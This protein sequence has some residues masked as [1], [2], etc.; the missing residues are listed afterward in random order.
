MTFK[1][2]M[3][4]LWKNKRILQYRCVALN[5]TSGIYLFSRVNEDNENCFYVGQAKNLLERTAQHLMGRTQ[6]I[7]KS[8]YKHK[9]WSPENLTGWNV[10]VLEYCSLNEL[11]RKEQEH[12][13][14]FLSKG[15]KSYNVTGGGQIDKA[16]DIGERQ[17]IK[18]KSYKNGKGLGYEKARNEVKVFFEKYLDFT[19]KG[20][21][22]KIKERKFNEFKEWLNGN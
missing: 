5:E 21:T 2:R 15:W 17:Q 12:I 18:L 14:Y 10:D 4:I 3:A 22:N 13:N 19:I 8:I 6:H 11:D 20:N 16:K 1:E 7:D 9:F